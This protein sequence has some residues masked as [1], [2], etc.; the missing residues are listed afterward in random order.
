MKQRS[1]RLKRQSDDLEIIAFRQN[2]SQSDLKK[3]NMKIISHLIPNQTRNVEISVLD[4]KKKRLEKDLK[5]SV[6][7]TVDD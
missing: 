3:L 4:K 6:C 7:V 1:Q 5:R 2:V